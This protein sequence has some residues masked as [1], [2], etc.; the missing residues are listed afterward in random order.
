MA[1][2]LNKLFKE[3]RKPGLIYTNQQLHMCTVRYDYLTRV[4]TEWKYIFL[5]MNCANC[6]KE[7]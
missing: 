7:Q 2:I 1:S 5:Q 4:N 3:P 6:S